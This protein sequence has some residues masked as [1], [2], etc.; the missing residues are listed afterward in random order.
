M[1]QSNWMGGYL[2]LRWSQ[3][4]IEPIITATNSHHAFH[5]SLDDMRFTADVADAPPDVPH[6]GLNN[7]LDWETHAQ[8]VGKPV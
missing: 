2:V 5:P 1:V 6:G 7:V 8:A 4:C 3:S